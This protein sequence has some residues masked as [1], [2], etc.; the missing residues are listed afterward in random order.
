MA[1]AASMFYY[2][3]HLLPYD[4]A[5]MLALLALWCGTGATRR[6]SLACGAA[7]AAAFITYNGY[8]LIAGAV[9]LLHIAQKGRTT[10]SAA[11]VR[12]AYAGLGFVIV[13]ALVVVAELSTGAPLM[14]AGMRRLAGTV[15][16]GYA[17]EGLTLPWAYLWHTEHGLLF[18]WIAALLFVTLARD[19]PDSRR[20]AAVMWVLAALFIYAG[21]GATS[22]LLHVFVVMGRQ[23][24]QMVPF[25]CLATAAVL[26]ELGEGPRR[27][28]RLVPLCMAALVLQAAW[29]FRTPLQQRFPRDV[30]AEITSKYGPIDFDTTIQGPAAIAPARRVAV[31]ALQCAAPVSSACAEAA[32][33]AVARRGAAVSPSAAVSSVSVRRVSTDGAAG[34]AR[35]RHCHA[36]G[37]RR[38][39]PSIGCREARA[40]SGRRQR[41][42]FLPRRGTGRPRHFLLSARLAVLP[43]SLPPDTS[44]HCGHARSRSGRRRTA[45]PTSDRR[46]SQG[47]PFDLPPAL[48]TTEAGP[49]VSTNNFGFPSRYDYPFLKA[50]NRQF[51]VGIFG[52]SVGAYFCRIGAPRFEADLRQNTFF[53]DRDIVTLCFS[54]EGY[55]QPQQ[56]L[57]LAYFLSIGQT[58]DM[59][60]N[61]D[62]FN[63]VGA[64]PAS[65][66]PTAGMCRCRATNISTR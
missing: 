5:M 57:V 56:L 9:L 1:S 53:R 58:F 19:R 51:I 27:S 34:V 6:D 62:G 3:R 61:I 42:R 66:T 44:T 13:P 30:I 52:G 15:T 2:A 18:L 10:R 65:T 41:S 4:S 46:T 33:A 45:T 16:D 25:F 63:E 20:R 40:D 8:W 31:G 38:G 47:I 50:S 29:N 55:K 28:P 36:A 22:S 54:H 17:P 12:A 11:L 60:V 59:V 49:L 35:Q 7:A 48:Q 32:L 24:R 23:T 26:R 37:G 39:A 64:R 14:F 21:L 43:R